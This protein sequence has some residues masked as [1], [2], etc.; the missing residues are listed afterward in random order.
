MT[1]TTTMTTTE[2]LPAPGADESVVASPHVADIEPAVPSSRL[3][4]LRSA[5]LRITAWYVL[6]IAIALAL[7]LVVVRQVLLAAMDDRIEQALLQEVDELRTLADGVDPADGE[8]FGERVDRLLEVFLRRNLPATDETMLSFVGGQPYL[9]SAG[10]PPVLL[11]EQPAL[12]ARWSDL[13]DVDRG[14]VDLDDVGTVEFLAVPLRADGA[15]RGVFVIAVFADIARGEVD[16]VTRVAGLVALLALALSTLLAW[17]VASRVL[18]PV[19]D[20]TRTA[21]AIT[22]TDL[23]RRIDVQGRDELAELAATFNA[24]LDRLQTAFATQRE[25]IDDAGHEL[26]TPITIIRGNLELL[27]DD[28]V[29]RAESVALVLDELDRMNRMVEDLLLLAKAETPDFL[30][31]QVVDLATLTAEVHAKAQAL[32]PRRWSLEL[33]GR[34]RV[35]ADRQRLTQAVVPLA[36]NATQHTAA[37]DEIALGSAVE[38]GEVRLWV[39]DTGPGIPHEEQDRIFARFTRGRDGRRRSEGAGL[40]LSIVRAIAEAH[41]GRIELDSRPGA[42]ATFTIVI[43]VDQPEEDRR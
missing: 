21:T 25:F 15:T 12:V 40:G 10:R 13:D 2:P 43:P 30:D 7:S 19:R 27:E 29:E 17:M 20:L 16:D 34:G 24:M 22:D 36:Q 33:Q 4:R 8:P 39:R 3:R 31:L 38:H 6:L 32:A 1:T 37:G 23:S 11:D 42:G 26:R 28:P 41:H 14:R 18:A 5:R 35:V 9:R